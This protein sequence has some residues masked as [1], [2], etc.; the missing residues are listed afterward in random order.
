MSTPRSREKSKRVLPNV[1]NASRPAG[2]RNTKVRFEKTDNMNSKPE[3]S[4]KRSAQNVIGAI[5]EE[6]VAGLVTLSDNYCADHVESKMSENGIKT[7]ELEENN[8]EASPVCS[9]A[10]P[11]TPITNGSSSSNLLHTVAANGN[12]HFNSPSPNMKVFHRTPIRR[13]TLD[14]RVFTTPECYKLVQFDRPYYDLGFDEGNGDGEDSCSVTVAVRLRP[15]S[16]R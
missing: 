10:A 16:A 2:V 8:I 11:S 6:K 5:P 1:P 14:E 15:F 7:C 4:N 9:K 12:F 3:S 13:H